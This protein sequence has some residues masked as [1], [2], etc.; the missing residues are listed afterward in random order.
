MYAEFQTSVGVKSFTLIL[1]SLNKCFQ[2]THLCCLS[3][4]WDTGAISQLTI[5]AQ[6]QDQE[7]NNLHTEDFNPSSSLSG[8]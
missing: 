3:Y 5:R 4:E 1:Y 8:I 2:T 6:Q 7:P